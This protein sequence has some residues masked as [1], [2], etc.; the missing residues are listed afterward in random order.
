MFFILSGFKGSYS[1]ADE[2]NFI[3]MIVAWEHHYT[4]KGKIPLK[5]WKHASSPTSQSI[6]ILLQDKLWHQ[7]YMKL[8]GVSHINFISSRTLPTII[9]L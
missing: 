6:V 4:L 3:Q 9:F 8:L 5:Q 7:P 1:V 2:R